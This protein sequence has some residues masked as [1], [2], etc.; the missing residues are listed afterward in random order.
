MQSE[1]VPQVRNAFFLTH[2]GSDQDDQILQLTS[3]FTADS[4]TM[5]YF[6]S[7]LNW[8]TSTQTAY[9]EVQ[10]SGEATWTTLSLIHI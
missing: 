10:E 2:T 6:E 8:A 3:T 1:V 5:L 4:S 9:V 7:R